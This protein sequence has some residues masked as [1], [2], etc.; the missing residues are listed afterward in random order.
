MAVS[1]ARGADPFGG[2]PSHDFDIRRLSGSDR[3][4]S[5]NNSDEHFFS[6]S[7]SLVISDLHTATNSP[8]G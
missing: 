8:L 6:V 2:S 1:R 5:D 3:A 7:S 4:R